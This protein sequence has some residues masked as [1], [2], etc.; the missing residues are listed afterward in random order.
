MPFCPPPKVHQTPL[1]FVPEIR[2]I[3]QHFFQIDMTQFPIDKM[4]HG[5]M[6]GCPKAID[7]LN[8]LGPSVRNHA[9]YKANK[10]KAGAGAELRHAF[11]LGEIESFSA[12]QSEE[13]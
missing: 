4:I 8:G 3:G 1:D 11:Q 9:V 10:T 2:K 5:A 12:Q 13:R 7:A 6:N